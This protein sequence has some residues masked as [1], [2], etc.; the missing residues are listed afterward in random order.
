MVL[1]SRVPA[2]SRKAS[3][4]EPERRDLVRTPRIGSL[5]LRI[6]GAAAGVGAGL[7]MMILGTRASLG[8]D[9]ARV[10]GFAGDSEGLW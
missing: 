6:G 4:R 5:V 9:P 7:L 2:G 3:P 1:L 8:G 10:V